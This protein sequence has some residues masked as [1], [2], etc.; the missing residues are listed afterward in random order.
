LHAAAFLCN[1][2]LVFGNGALGS[3]DA[4]GQRIALGLGGA[5]AFLG[6][7]DFAESAAVLL[8]EFAQAFLVELD[9][10]F[11]PFG[12]SL[13]FH[14][15]VLGL[16]DFVIEFG[17]AFTQLEDFVFDPQHGGAEGL[18]IVAKVLGR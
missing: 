2:I 4:F 6:L 12:L 13:E 11:V 16:G 18:G 9:P 1:R 7:G 10:G 3:G 17:E 14:P 15:P 5:G 8:F